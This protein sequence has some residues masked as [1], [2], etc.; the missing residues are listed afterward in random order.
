MSV[1]FDYIVNAIWRSD[2]AWAFPIRTDCVTSFLNVVVEVVYQH[3]IRYGEN[4]IVRIYTV[5]S[6]CP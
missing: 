1:T 6:L 4:I 5:I 2:L 3:M